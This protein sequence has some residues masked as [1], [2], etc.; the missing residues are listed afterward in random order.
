MV[1]RW[2]LSFPTK[3]KRPAWRQ[4]ARCPK[5]GTGSLNRHRCKFDHLLRLKVRWR[6]QSQARRACSRSISADASESCRKHPTTAS[7]VSLTLAL[8]LDTGQRVRRSR[9]L[10]A[11][12]AAA[13][14]PAHAA[15][16]ARTTGA[17]WPGCRSIPRFG[18]T[19]DTKKGRMGVVVQLPPGPRV[20][21]LPGG[22]LRSPENMPCSARWVCARALCQLC[23]R[24]KVGT[25]GTARV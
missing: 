6:W 8:N 24:G 13:V 4:S 1:R 20:R 9:W 19:R 12:K 18:A 23:Q 17:G 10:N 16:A 2:S 21:R 25:A 22:S 7:P 14:S 11:R 3:T 5:P 15:C